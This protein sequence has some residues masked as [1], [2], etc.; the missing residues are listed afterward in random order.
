M[1]KDN[2]SYKRFITKHRTTFICLF[3][4]LS[5]L[6]VYWQILSHDFVNFDDITYVI[7]NDKIKS[8]FTLDAIRWAFNLKGTER[9]YWH[10]LTWLSHILDIQLFGLN[11]SMHHMINLILHLLS[12]LL[13]FYVFFKMTDDIWK[14][15]IV[16]LLFGIHPINVESVAWIA[17]RKNMLST[18][19]WMMT[20]VLYVRYVKKPNIINYCLTFVAFL[21]GLLAKPMLITLPFVLLLLDYW[22]IN[23]FNIKS[24]AGTDIIQTPT[25]KNRQGKKSSTQFIFLEKVPFLIIAFA[26]VYIAASSAEGKFSIS[27]EVVPLILRFE[28]ALVSYVMYIIKMLWPSNLAVLYP[29]PKMIEPWKVISATIF[30]IS[31]SLIVIYFCRKKPYLFVGWFWFAGTLVPV[32]GIIQAGLWPS[33]ADRWAY[34]PFI[35]LFIILTWLLPEWLKRWKYQRHAFTIIAFIVFPFLMLQ[36]WVQASYWSNGTFLFKHAIDVNENNYIAHNNLG[37]ALASQGKHTEALYHYDKAI[38]LLPNYK[39]AQI[40]YAKALYKTGQIDKAI[41]YLSSKLSNIYPEDKKVITILG[42]VMLEKGDTDSAIHYFNNALKIDPEDIDAL[43]GAGSAF[44]KL[45]KTDKAIENFSKVLMIDSFNALAHYNLGVIKERQGKTTEAIHH[46]SEAIRISPKSTDALTNLASIMADQGSMDRAIEY[47][48]KALKA[49]PSNADI[50]Y[51]LGII[52]LR[53][54]RANDAIQYFQNAIQLNPDFVP[55]RKALDQVLGNKGRPEESVDKI[56]AAIN[57]DPNNPSLYSQ[58]GRLYFRSGDMDK[59]IIYYEK[60]LSIKPDFLEA[61]NGLA[62]LYAAKKEYENAIPYFK[63]IVQLNPENASPYF[64]VACMYSRLNNVEKSIDWL[65]KA[66]NRGYDNWDLIK[67]DKD[68]ENIRESSHF[69]EILQSEPKDN[70]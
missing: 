49:D 6:S 11:P 50:C 56:K 15:T 32:S 69:K 7:D 64:N 38:Q 4:L 60:A 66:I 2:N 65:R 47:L 8:G 13:L 14:S 67:N 51:N 44:N 25:F 18:F 70:K 63:K 16:A 59:A 9:S 10:P 5:I 21:L 68:L 62:I 46:Y 12:S 52:S 54:G 45:G 41:E 24:I 20:I 42:N 61:L 55:A 36:T 22:P 53:V 33:M 58:L 19:F 28:N 39:N 57:R 1:T 26:V 48:N 34:I 23:R 30:L 37:S 43:I 17:E 29:F 3:L 27:F 31:V 35:G 40:N